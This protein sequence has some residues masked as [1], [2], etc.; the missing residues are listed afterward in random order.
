MS[1]IQVKVHH[2]FFYSGWE[3]PHWFARE[4]DDHGYKPSFRRTNWFEPVGREVDLVMKRAGVID[5]TPF[6]KLE[7]KGPDAYSFIDTICANEV[8]KVGTQ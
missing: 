4:G 1:I 6:G 2:C 5:L 3:Q 8:P 7:V